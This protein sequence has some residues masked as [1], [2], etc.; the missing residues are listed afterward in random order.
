MLRKST[1]QKV[2]TLIAYDNLRGP[3]GGDALKRLTDLPYLDVLLDSGAFAAFRQ[4]DPIDLDQ[5]IEFLK[6]HSGK[7]FGYFALDV[8]GDK[9]ATMSNLRR[10]RRAGLKPIPILT[11]GNSQKDMEVMFDG[12]DFIGIGGI[13]GK[14]WPHSKA[15]KISYLKM[16][17]KWSRRRKVHYLGVASEEI[18]R[19]FKPFSCDTSSWLN[20]AKFGHLSIYFGNGR[21]RHLRTDNRAREIDREIQLE[22]TRAGFTLN[23]LM[24]TTLWNNQNDTV[25]SGQ[26][27]LVHLTCRSWIKY[28]LE[29]E[30]RFKT[31]I[32]LVSGSM[33][34]ALGSHPIPSQGARLLG[35]EIRDDLLEVDESEPVRGKKTKKKK[36]QKK[37]KRKNMFN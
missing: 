27:I 11:V 22:V 2:P 36:K 21:W 31:K 15:A 17:K 19:T 13:Q 35:Y 9:K 10:M 6:E 28:I 16:I 30:A 12:A 37:T 32:F 5:Y 26:S 14:I 24:D 18:L 25:L 3:G 34:T 23:D 4:G 33:G 7:L 20:A 1:S 8:I 29:F